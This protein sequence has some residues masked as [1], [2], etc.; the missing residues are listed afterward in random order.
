MPSR[1][2]VSSLASRTTDASIPSVSTPYPT[3]HH[4]FLPSIRLT[5]RSPLST[6]V[7]HTS[8]VRHHQ[9]RSHETAHIELDFAYVHMDLNRAVGPRRRHPPLWAITHRESRS[10]GPATSCHGIAHSSRSS[11]SPFNKNAI[12]LVLNRTGTGELV[13]F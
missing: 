5:V 9:R 3:I 8:M 13:R 10:T 12:T 6:R 1:F 7:V 11:K 2:G 4:W